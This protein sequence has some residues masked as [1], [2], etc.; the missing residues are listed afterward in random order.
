MFFIDAHEAVFF[1]DQDTQ[2]VAGV[3]HFGG[4]G[5]MAGA[6]CIHAHFLELQEA[7]YLQGVGNAGAYAGV[8]LMHVHAFQFYA[9]TV[10]EEAFVRVEHG[11][12]DTGFGLIDVQHPASSEDFCCNPIYI[13]VFRAPEKGAFYLHPCGC[14]PL[15]PGFQR[16]GRSRTGCHHLSVGVCERVAK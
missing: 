14:S 7:V 2:A 3:Q 16:G 4:H 1:Q 6:V 8:I 10:K 11:F 12:P 5:V 9:F 15:L 13:R